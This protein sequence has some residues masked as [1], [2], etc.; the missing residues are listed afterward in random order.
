MVRAT[1]TL[2]LVL[3]VA[4]CGTLSNLGQGLGIG[5][6]QVLFEGQRFRAKAQAVERRDKQEFVVS[7]RP[8]QASLDGARQAAEYQGVRHCIKY[9]G[10]SDIDWQIGPDTDPGSLPIDGDTLTF[11]GSCIDR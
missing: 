8:V 6:K 1:I 10:T 2:G 4:G 7:V 5:R 3:L 11:R 9:F